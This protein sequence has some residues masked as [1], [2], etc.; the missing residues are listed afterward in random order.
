MVVAIDSRNSKRSIVRSRRSVRTSRRPTPAMMSTAASAVLG[1]KRRGP[2]R[3][4]TTAAVAA[5]AKS[6]V[7]R[8]LPPAASLTAVRE[9]A[10][11]MTKPCERP[12]EIL[13]MPRAMKSWLASIS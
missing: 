13:A 11:L 5:A 9:S 8:D 3:K 6:P 2:V 7:T 4:S 1:M 12:D 10:P